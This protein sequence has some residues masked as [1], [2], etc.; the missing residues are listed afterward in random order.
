M[1]VAVPLRVSTDL[2]K[3]VCDPAPTPDCTCVSS[4]SILGN[5]NNS[6]V[7]GGAEKRITRAT[8]TVAAAAAWQRPVNREQPRG[9]SS[10]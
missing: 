3:C 10:I 8:S 4:H 2:S 9:A 1:C 5:K 6:V 7:N